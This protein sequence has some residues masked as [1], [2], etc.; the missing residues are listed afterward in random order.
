ME[1]NMESK[2]KATNSTDKETKNDA[3]ESG[4]TLY[5]NLIT[6]EG[7]REKRKRAP[8]ELQ[9]LKY[10]KQLPGRK[11]MAEK[12]ERMEIHSHLSHT[13]KQEVAKINPTKGKEVEVQ[14]PK[15]SKGGAE[16]PS[17]GR[18]VETDNTYKIQ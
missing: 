15:G 13:A 7:R 11:E 17:M 3:E 10:A 1:F 6:D 16:N 5:P 8:E 12:H 14:D 2:T 18:R 4:N 9:K